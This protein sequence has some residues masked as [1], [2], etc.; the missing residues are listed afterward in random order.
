[1]TIAQ[2]FAVGRYEVTFAEWDACLAEGGCNGDRLR[3][4]KWGRGSRP[5]INASW[6]QAQ[7]YLAWLSQK[8][9]KPYRLLSEAEWEYAV[10]AGTT[11]TYY[12]GEQ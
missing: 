7:A 2:P 5:V 6:A 1:M 8:T 3:D 12:W 10:R 9:G 11:T 4:K